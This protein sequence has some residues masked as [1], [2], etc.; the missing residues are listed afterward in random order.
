MGYRDD[1]VA[2]LLSERARLEEQVDDL[3]RENAR[4]RD[5]AGHHKSRLRRAAAVL[6]KPIA[7]GGIAT[8]IVT[9]IA[10]FVFD[11]CSVDDQPELR[12]GYVTDHWLV[13]AHTYTTTTCVNV[14]KV[15]VCTPHV[16]HVPTRYYVIIAHGG[17]SREVGLAHRNWEGTAEGRWLCIDSPCQ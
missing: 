12:A 17:Q 15:P 8:A 16:H 7:V 10:L 2:R 14:G 13:P 11:R 5:E 6:M 1:E 3:T 9:A 4:M